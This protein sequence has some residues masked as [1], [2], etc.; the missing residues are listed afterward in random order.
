MADNYTKAREVAEY[1]FGDGVIGG[2]TEL[3]G[4]EKMT[5]KEKAA[6]KSNLI[7]AFAYTSAMGH[8]SQELA[9][10]SFNAFQ[11]KLAEVGTNTQI[12]EKFGAVA[13]LKMASLKDTTSY[14]QANREE[15]RVISE[16]NKIENEIIELQKGEQSE[17]KVNKLKELS[18]KIIDLSKE[19]EKHRSNKEL[20]WNS[21]SDNFFN[22]SQFIVFISHSLPNP[23][24]FAIAFAVSP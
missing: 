4:K 23:I 8:V 20:Y 7:D 2:L 9:G 17:Q 24:F 12:V 18:D 6:M 11:Q 15:K 1:I 13:A 16:K 22:L 10:D 14:E 5:S 3:S 21:I 19:I